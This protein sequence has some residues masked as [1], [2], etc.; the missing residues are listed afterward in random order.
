[1]APAEV[2]HERVPGGDDPR[3]PVTFQSAHRPEP[4]FQPSVIGFDLC[5]PRSPSTAL[6]SGVARPALWA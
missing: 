6:T 1:V 2:L 5:V 3:G 4:C